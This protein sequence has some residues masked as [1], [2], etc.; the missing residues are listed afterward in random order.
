MNKTVQTFYE[1]NGFNKATSNF[2]SEQEYSKDDLLEMA[3]QAADN[4]LTEN[5]AE[6]LESMNVNYR[7]ADTAYQW[8][9]SKELLDLGVSPETIYILALYCN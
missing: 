9:L 8:Q 6:S 7:K 5:I 3:T 4:Q 2:Q 1:I